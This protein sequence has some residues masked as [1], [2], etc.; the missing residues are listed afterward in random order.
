MSMSF[1]EKTRK[2]LIEAN[3]HIVVDPEEMCQVRA[4]TQKDHHIDCINDNGF[5]FGI[6]GKGRAIRGKETIE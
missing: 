4:N 1:Y 3:E 5:V 6:P 2:G